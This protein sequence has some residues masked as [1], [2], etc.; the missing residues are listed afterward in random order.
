MGPHLVHGGVERLHTAVESLQ[1]HGA[2]PVG[3]AAQ[4]PGPDE[5]P[6]TVGAHELRAVQ[7]GQSLL[8]LELNGAPPLRLQHLGSGNDLP[9]ILHLAQTE[10]RQ[11][12]VGQRCQVARGAQ[13][14]LL[15]DDGEDIGVEKIGQTL[16][17]AELNARVAVGE[18]LDLEEQHQP[19][20]LVRDALAGAAGVG[21]HQVLLQ[22][23][24]L[25]GLHG[26]IA[27]RAET[28]RNTVD[29]LLAG[30][31][32]PVEILAA[33]DDAR[34]GVVAQRKG[35][36]SVQNLLDTVDGEVGGTDFVIHICF[37]SFSG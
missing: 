30:L 18:R 6:D 9:F 15:I 33:A 12:Q 27:E 37:G 25:V 21:H 14:P 32:L 34:T 24:Q 16:D 28:G 29:G 17:G 35:V 4:P 19:D 26:D 22:L 20:D 2:D 1:R 8:R 31:H 7:Q 5:R 13:R 11:A 10:Q 3:G 36:V 23:G